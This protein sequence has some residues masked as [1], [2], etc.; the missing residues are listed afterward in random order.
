MLVLIMSRENYPGARIGG[1]GYSGSGT[2]EQDGRGERSRRDA[3]AGVVVLLP[4]AVR[5][6][7]ELASD[8]R[9]DRRLVGDAPVPIEQLGADDPRARRVEDEAHDARGRDAVL[10]RDDRTAIPGDSVAAERRRVRR[11]VEACHGSA[12]EV[13]AQQPM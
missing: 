10:H 3:T 11:I 4:L 6:V 8:H 9:A 2:G 13:D 7:H 5:D 1:A 12:T